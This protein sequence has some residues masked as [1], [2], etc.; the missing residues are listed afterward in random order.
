MTGPR[1]GDPLDKDMC[2]AFGGDAAAL[3]LSVRG[4][5]HTKTGGRLGLRLDDPNA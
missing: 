5:L 3:Q 1:E 4:V 2:V